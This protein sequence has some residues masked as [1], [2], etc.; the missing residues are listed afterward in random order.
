MQRWNFLQFFAEC[1]DDYPVL[2]GALRAISESMGNG[3]L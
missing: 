1:R 3:T 2:E